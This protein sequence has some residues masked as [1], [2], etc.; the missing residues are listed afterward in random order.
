MRRPAALAALSGLSG[1]TTS[2]TGASLPW[3]RPLAVAGAAAVGW[4]L[5][6]MGPVPRRAITV[7]AMAASFWLLTAV[8]RAD[9][10]SPDSSRYLYVGAV[11]CVLLAAEL[12]RGVRFSVLAVACLS[13]LVALAGL[14]NLG[15]LRD[16][17]RLLREQAAIARADL[18]ALE[19]A[20]ATV[21]ADHVA[22]AFPGYPFLQIRADTYFD[23]AR[24]LGS[25]AFT[26]A[27]LTGTSEAA[28]AAADRELTAAEGLAL[29]PAA[30]ADVA[31]AP[32]SVDGAISGTAIRRDDC[33]RFRPDAVRADGDMPEL[34]LTLPSGGVHIRSRSGSTILGL[35][36]FAS[37]F[38]ETELG[39][40]TGA[41]SAELRLRPDSGDAR[42]HLRVRPDA[43]VTACGLS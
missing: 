40:L 8:Q 23:A 20:R 14:A 30:D 43:G 5:W 3:G 11:L 19:L 21:P 26:P 36:R 29:R 35:R 39:R 28:R 13:G 27:E 41:S 42:W 25:P 38:P 22:V 10:S 12:S 16:A 7:S 31:G 9:E 17:S 33:V 1:V 24:E 4:R 37:S 32:L 18:T 15:D 6:T 2:D 34:Q